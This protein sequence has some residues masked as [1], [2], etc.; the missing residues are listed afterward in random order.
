MKKPSLLNW[1]LASKFLACRCKTTGKQ[2]V[3]IELSCSFT[4]ALSSNAGLP[5][6][7]N[8]VETLTC[9]LYIN[10]DNIY[11]ASSRAIDRPAFFFW[12]VSIKVRL[13]ASLS[14]Q[15]KWQIVPIFI[16][17]WRCGAVIYKKI[18]F[19]R[20]ECSL[21]KLIFGRTKRNSLQRV[22]TQSRAMKQHHTEF[23]TIHTW[24]TFWGYNVVEWVSRIFQRFCFLNLF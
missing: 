23:F 3:K 1:C 24:H 15:L 12:L 19:V 14:W 5:P 17:S 2:A 7:V 13:I 9:W 20:V 21:Q 18:N 10:F 6:S 16:Q 11:A 8:Y 4:S 22:F